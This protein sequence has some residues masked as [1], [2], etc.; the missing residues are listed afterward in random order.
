LLVKVGPH[1]VSLIRESDKIRKTRISKTVPKILVLL[2]KARPRCHALP[3]LP[4]ACGY[5]STLD[6]VTFSRHFTSHVTFS[7]HF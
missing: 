7:R 4:A 2:V 3:V 6:H 1:S 5:G